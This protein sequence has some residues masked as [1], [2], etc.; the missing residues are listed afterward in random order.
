MPVAVANN[1]LVIFD[2]SGTAD[3]SGV[4]SGA[5]DVTKTGNGRVSL[6][7]AQTWMGATTVADGELTVPV[8]LAT[9]DV[10]VQSGARL[11]G[12]GTIGGSVLI[13]AGATIAPGDGIASF[14]VGATTFEAGSVYEVDLNPNGS[15]SDLLMVTGTLDLL[16]GNVDMILPGDPGL[17]PGE[18]FTYHCR[19]PF[20]RT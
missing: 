5:G 9:S 2:E 18:S 13:E 10:T 7:G 8:S 3:Y 6:L 17:N 14:A 19:T 12:A 11:S 15:S 4:I 16:G 1:A 20:P